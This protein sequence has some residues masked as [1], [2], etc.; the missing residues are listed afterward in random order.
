MF[1]TLYKVLSEQRVEIPI[2]Q[3]DYAQGRENKVFLRERLLGKMVQALRGSAPADVLNLDFVYGTN[4]HG[5][6][7]P[8]DGQQRLTTLWLLH[9]YLA[10]R[11]N[12]LAQAKEWLGRFTYETRATSRDFCRCLCNLDAEAFNRSGMRL[13]DFIEN[14]TWFFSKYRLDPTIRGMLRTLG[15][16]GSQSSA[17]GLVCDGIE[18]LLAD[19]DHCSLYW[20]RL[21]ADDCPIRFL[22][23]DMKDENLPLSDDLYIKMNARGKQ[24]TD[25]ENF[26]ADLMGFVPDERRPEVKLFD[27]ATAS[28]M[29][30]EWTDVFWKVASAKG[31]FKVDAIYFEFLRRYF[32]DRL[33]ATST[34]HVADLQQQPLYRDLYGGKEHYDG[35]HDYGEVLKPEMVSGLKKLLARWNWVQLAPYWDCSEVFAFIPEYVVAERAS[36]SGSTSVSD[37]TGVSAITLKQRVVFHAVCCYFEENEVFEPVRFDQWMHFVWNVVENGYLYH[38]DDMIGAIRLLEELRAKSGNILTFL[39]SDE[40]I[41]SNFAAKQVE[42]ERFKA[43]LLCGAEADLWRP[44]ITEAEQMLFFKGNIACLLRHDALAFV[45]DRKCFATKLAH[46]QHLFDAQAVRQKFALPLTRALI[47]QVHA[48]NQLREQYIFDTSASAWKEHILHGLKPDY[49]REVHALLMAD[50]VSLLPLVPVEDLDA[51]EAASTNRLKRLLADTPFLEAEPY[52]RYSLMVSEGSEWRL[53][54]GY[55]VVSFFPFGRGH[56]YCFDW[57]RSNSGYTFRRNALLSCKDVEVWNQNVCNEGVFWDWKVFFSFHDHA[58][59]WGN[60]NVVSLLA[61]KNRKLRDA[62]HRNERGDKYFSLLMNEWPQVSHSE[63]LALLDGLIA[64]AK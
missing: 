9:W 8:L 2:L 19:D 45:N 53:H 60:D 59:E 11:S 13:V 28:L 14:Q 41:D 4:E 17:Q 38:D 27:H 15:G 7:W 31:I 37:Y 48:W 22:F 34:H 58:F 64:E 55:G 47:R 46:V 10:V 42:E 52:E 62:Q 25:F 3:R 29:D 44:L 21:L 35:L 24:L 18:L 61:G 63:F 50:D 23:K 51:G 33:I 1:Q 32:L 26:K 16:S 30:N 39:A 6:M 12:Q 40:K 5:A 54:W 43:H 57:E 56:A 49:V 36:S 20:E